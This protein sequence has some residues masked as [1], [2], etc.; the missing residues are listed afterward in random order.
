MR[1]VVIGQMASYVVAFRGDLLQRF[2]ELGHEVVAMAPE[3]D[4][5]ARQ[6]LAAI[7]VA[8]E[9][10]PIE[11]TGMDPLRDMGSVT[12]LVRVFRRV[13]PDMVL[14][15]GAKPVIYGSLAARAAGVPVRVAMITGVGSALGGGGSLGRRSLA[16]L[17]RVM[18]AVA[19]RGVRL[20]IFQNQDDAA[21]FR[22]LGLI[23]S[24]QRTLV[25][26][27]SGVHLERFPLAPLP[28]PPVKFLMIGRLIRDKGVN[29]YVDA[30]RIVRRERPGATFQLLGP[31]DSNP[32]AVSP[33]QLGRWVDE[34]V[35][36]YLG[37]TTDVRP[38]IG[39]AHACVLPS[40]REG[41]PR[42]VLEAMSMG[43]PIVTTDVP[44]CRETVHEGRNGHLVPARDPAALAA[45]M[46][47]LMEVDDDALANMGR[48]S[49]RMAET[50]FDVH[51]VNRVIIEA[52]GLAGDG[53]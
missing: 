24:R 19:L 45:A 32:S 12:A 18:Y 39:A 31:L 29:E 14:G 30:A 38:F 17:L 6:A 33:E 35:I 42:S 11:R 16:R 21:L 13:R 52:L 26:N 47:R 7:G 22:E 34:G 53:G 40:Y 9:P 3:D 15:T 48:E 5:Q 44:G 27:G 43:R 4:T 50:A 23:P 1:I 49:R 46:V 28:P 20:V 37:E 25:V 36:D 51:E 10:A 8:Y 41:V 2:V